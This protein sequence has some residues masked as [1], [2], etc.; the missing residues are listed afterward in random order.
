MEKLDKAAVPPDFLRLQQ[1]L[2]LIMEMIGHPRSPRGFDDPANR[3]SGGVGGVVAEL[4]HETQASRRTLRRSSL[5]DVVPAATC[6]KPFWNIGCMPE[7]Q[8]AL[9]M[10]TW[11]ARAR[12]RRSIESSGA[13]NS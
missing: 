6:R 10:A 8:A 2:P 13:S 12:M 5:S 3:L 1:K 11:S 7:R 4:R 9:W